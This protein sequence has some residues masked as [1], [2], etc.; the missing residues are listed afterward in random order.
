MPE[1]FYFYYMYLN[2]WEFIIQW[3]KTQQI[4]VNILLHYKPMGRTLHC[5]LKVACVKPWI[6]FD[7][8]SLLLLG[9]KKTSDFCFVIY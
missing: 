6:T 3:N 5:G 2:K 4:G 1:S 7:R 8:I 9:V